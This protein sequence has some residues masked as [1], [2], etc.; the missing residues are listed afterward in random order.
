MRS[1]DTINGLYETEL[2]RLRDPWRILD[3][4]ELATAELTDWFNH[5]RLYEHFVDV[6]P[7][8]LEDAYYAQ[9]RAEPTVALSTPYVSGLTGAGSGDWDDWTVQPRNDRAMDDALLWITAI[10]SLLTACATTALVWVA[11][12]TLNGAREQLRLLRE[13][14]AREGRP[15]VVAEI[16]P[17]LHGAGSS[18]L[19][20]RNVGRTIALAITVEVNKIADRGPGDYISGALMQYLAEPRTL[21]PGSRQRVMW[22]AEPSDSGRGEAGAARRVSGQVNYRDETGAKYSETYDLSVETISKSSPIPTEG[23]RVH[24]DGKELAN[25]ER[26]L[27]TLNGHVGELRR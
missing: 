16:V 11:W 6:P 20:L 19:V 27:R 7:A 22:R 25:I 8:E 5:R 4:V 21:A 9:N 13:Q 23:P 18:D 10:G 15:Y 14:A 17:G 24:G 26:A 2:I 12:R 1:A 3:H